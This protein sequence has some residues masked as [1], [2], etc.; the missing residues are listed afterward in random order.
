MEDK[1]TI[2]MQAE[3]VSFASTL[4]HPHLLLPLIHVPFSLHPSPYPSTYFIEAQK[5]RKSWILSYVIWLLASDVDIILLD[6]D[7]NSL[8]SNL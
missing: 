4:P 6:H 1:S 7:W 5:I 8:N 2:D 3:I